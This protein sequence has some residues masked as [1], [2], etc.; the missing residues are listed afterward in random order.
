MIVEDQ[1][2][3]LSVGSFHEV[4]KLKFIHKMFK[5]FSQE[6]RETVV[7][8]P[9]SPRR[10]SSGQTPDVRFQTPWTFFVSK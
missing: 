2:N 1:V 3:V 9:N 6:V 10:A 4:R 7:E 8:F 5:K